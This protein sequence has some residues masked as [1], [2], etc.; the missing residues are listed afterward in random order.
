MMAAFIVAINGSVKQAIL[1]GISATI[2]H[3]LV[4]WIV[5]LTGMY[6]MNGK[7]DSE[8]TEPY[9]QMVSGFLM[10]LI[11]ILMMWRNFK[12]QKSFQKNSEA[13][14][15]HSHEH[16]DAHELGH[17]KEIEQ[18]FARQNIRQ[19]ISSAQVITFGLTGGL[20][21]CP[22]SITVLLLCLQLKKIAMGALL[23]FCFSIG[24][25]LV[26]VA[27]GVLAAVSI[28]QVSNRW[29][30]FGKLAKNASYL[31]GVLIAIIGIYVIYHGLI[32]I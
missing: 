32:Q 31:S 20:I 27:S 30:G 23:V 26:L 7:I 11:A 22:A 4:V 15:H 10:L 17:A 6:F 16:Q 14:N 25:A 3:T 9:F 5:V 28:K 24:L 19:N 8:E 21:P 1:L 13:K 29:S 18:R 12:N 2:S